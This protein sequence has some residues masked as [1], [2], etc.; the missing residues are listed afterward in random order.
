MTLPVGPSTSCLCVQRL[1]DQALSLQPLTH[2]CRFP[3]AQPPRWLPR[4]LHALEGLEEKGACRPPTVRLLRMPRSPRCPDKQ[5]R[6][7]KC[8]HISS[9][10]VLGIWAGTVYPT[11]A[12]EEQASG[13]CVLA[14]TCQVWTIL[15]GVFYRTPTSRK[16]IK[17]PQVPITCP[18]ASV[19][20]RCTAVWLGHAELTCTACHN[21][22]QAAPGDSRAGPRPLICCQDES[23]CDSHQ[24][25]A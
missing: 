16:I 18:G 9:R 1:P 10:A 4:L 6:V 12:R 14:S 7:L 5:G 21:D 25:F 8:K 3:A 20:I 24:S 23:T 11:L 2:L 22:S 15:T 17:V 19:L 13:V